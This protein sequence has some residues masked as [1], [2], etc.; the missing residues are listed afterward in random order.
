MQALQETFHGASFDYRAG[1]PHLKHWQLFDRLV[2]LLQQQVESVQSRGLPLTLLDVGAGHG[3][4]TEPALA[5]GCRVT[6][7]EMSRPSLTRLLDRYRFNTAFSAVF[8]ADGSLDVLGSQTF[9]VVLCS[10]VLHHIPDYL[11]FIHGSVLPQ[12]APGGT[13]ITIQDPLWYPK[14][15]RRDLLLTKVGY[16][17]W[18]LTQGNYIQGARTRLR[19]IRK[20]YDENNPADMVEYHVVRS[21][22]DQ[23]R[24]WG[25]LL[26]YFKGVTLHAYW[27]SQSPTYQRIGELIGR[28]NTFAL[29]ANDYQG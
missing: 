7:T 22:V 12:L 14:M 28:H 18:R 29:V 15:T 10:S 6:A 26:P 27:S 19:R 24:L 20:I 4:Y 21:G 8:D 9:S 3:G 25:S 5:F 11:N 17:T 16:F 13:L 1:S 23:E 2:A